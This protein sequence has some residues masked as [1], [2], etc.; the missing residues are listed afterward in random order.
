MVPRFPLYFVGIMMT[1]ILWYNYWFMVSMMDS[2][3]SVIL[4]TSIAVNSVIRYKDN[5]KI[6][7]STI[8]EIWY[9]SFRY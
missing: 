4:S 6:K 5:S 9:F 1:L 8:F 3:N 7:K 2:F